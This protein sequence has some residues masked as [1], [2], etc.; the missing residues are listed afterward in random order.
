MHKI[1]FNGINKNFIKVVHL[2]Y[3]KAW[4]NERVYVCEIGKII[5]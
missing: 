4:I 3:T 2:Y 5:Y 1:Y